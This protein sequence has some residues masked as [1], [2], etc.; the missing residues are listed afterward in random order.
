[1][2]A[3]SND[4]PRV[5]VGQVWSPRRSPDVRRTVVGFAGAG[6]ARPRPGR[7][8][9]AHRLAGP[10]PPRGGAGG[11]GLGA[12]PAPDVTASPAVGTVADGIAT[13]T[14]PEGWDEVFDRDRE[15]D[16]RLLVFLLTRRPN[17]DAAEGVDLTSTL[18]DA[19]VP[20]DDDLN[21]IPSAPPTGMTAMGKFDRAMLR[22][23]VDRVGMN[24]TAWSDTDLLRD[25]EYHLVGPDHT[26]GASVEYGV[27][28]YF[29]SR[30]HLMHRVELRH[31]SPIPQ[32][33]GMLGAL[34]Y[35]LTALDGWR[36]AADA[37]R[38]LTDA[39]RPARADD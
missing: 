36:R 24:L 4:R 13:V 23:A 5:R 12:P 31:S 38:T 11:G 10:G 14:L 16:L 17:E 34:G 29:G 28:D 2:S 30:L 20:V 33:G 39:A 25:F 8:P 1:M 18:G 26:E 32:V 19:T 22:N 6:G 27:M 9:P 37:A 21:T 35:A 3:Q 7:A 15:D